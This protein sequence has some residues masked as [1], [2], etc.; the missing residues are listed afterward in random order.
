MSLVPLNNGAGLTRKIG[1]P[2]NLVDLEPKWVGN[3]SWQYGISFLCPCCKKQRLSI[4]F[5]PV[6]N[7]PE[8][9][10]RGISGGK[11]EGVPLW[12]RT[13]TTFETLTLDPSMDFSASG[14]WHGNIINGKVITP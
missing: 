1:M 6:I 2:I 3:A 11:P 7:P 14:H 4:S 13:G 9:M 5:E 8:W 10:Q 12:K